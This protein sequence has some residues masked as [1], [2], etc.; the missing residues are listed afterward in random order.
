MKNLINNLEL[1]INLA[2]KNQDLLEQ[3]GESYDED[4]VCNLKS[5]FIIKHQ[6]KLTE[7]QIDYISKI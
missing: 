6:S 4:Y 3:I 5:D 2:F 7:D 1:R